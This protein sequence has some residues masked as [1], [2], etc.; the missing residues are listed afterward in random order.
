MS[1]KNILTNSLLPSAGVLASRVYQ[2]EE[3]TAS[4][5]VWGLEQQSASGPCYRNFISILILLFI[6]INIITIIIIIGCP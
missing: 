6:I 4:E 1:K 3:R 2:P 5:V